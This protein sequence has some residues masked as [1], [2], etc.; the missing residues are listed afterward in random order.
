MKGYINID[1]ERIGEVDFM[2]T[3]EK[4]GCIG[5]PLVPYPA[6]DKFKIKIQLICENKGIANVD[7]FNFSAFLGDEII[8]NPEGGIGITDIR[9]FDEIIVECNGISSEIIGAFST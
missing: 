6:Y 8:L 2:V 5:G 7:D 1:D 4:M 3:D 9:D